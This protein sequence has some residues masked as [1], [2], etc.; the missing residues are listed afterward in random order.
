MAYIINKYS[1]EPLVNLEDGTLDTSTSL[2][3]I[4]RNYVG[5]GETQNEN[6]VYLLENF[7]NPAAPPTPLVGQLWYNTETK[8][9]NAYNGQTWSPVGNAE[10]SS[11]APYP[12][13]EGQL[14]YKVTTNQLYIYESGD[15]NLIGPTALEGFAE[16][17]WKASILIDSDGNEKPVLLSIV[18]GNVEAIMADEHFS[19]ALSN[20]IDGFFDIR[21]GLNIKST[22]RVIG[23]LTGNADTATALKDPRTIN[24]VS[25]D[26]TSNITV[27]ASTTNLLKKGT[28]ISGSNFN[29]SS[30][31]TWSIDASSENIIGKIVARDT[32]GNFSAGTVTA[33]LVG[34]V[35]GNIN[36]VGSSTFNNVTATT[37]F[38]PLS[39]NASSA[40]KLNVSRN[41]NGVPFNG[42]A[43]IVVPAESSTL[44]GDTLST[45][46]VNSSLTSVGVLTE[47]SIADQ[48]I[49]LGSGNH[50]KIFVDG[51]DP[52][53]RV[54]NNQK[55][56]VSIV[57][58]GESSGVADFSFISSTVALSLSGD[59]AP[60][61]IPTTAGTANL[62]Q[63]FAKWNKIYANSFDGY[64]SAD[65]IK[66]GIR[67]SIPYQTNTNTTGLLSIGTAGQILAVSPAG[68]PQWISGSSTNTANTI[69]S[70]DASGNFSA[71]TIT[72]S[73][74][75]TA[76]NAS[77][78]VTATRLATPRKI[79]GVNFDGTA[80][81]TVSSSYTFTYGNTSYAVG[82]TNQVGSWNNGSNFVDVFPPAGKSMGN[83]I[84]F[85]PSISVIHYAGGVNGDDS[86][87]CTWSNLGDRIRIYVQN[88]EQRS[89]PAA[90]WLAIW[91]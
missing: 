55:L 52:T 30:E 65:A 80:D 10:V 63:P 6:F 28:Y 27:T 67:G 73:L 3:L 19:I 1:G 18:N 44:T 32:L 22:R 39:G 59:D 53:I 71:G 69:V 54:A 81:I 24:G 45:S 84:A 60:A 78:S 86:M 49:N 74:I 13:T 35:I 29:G 61:L 89:T 31:V 58:S 79:N 43:D 68:I 83:L 87:R 9:V 66:G 40:S 82:Y 4:G 64:I 56:K 16:T 42:Q 26:G 76:T 46:V 8:I 23:N 70:R 25:F 21:P 36:S 41:I 90:N 85:I 20:S 11:I 17:Q 5:Y 88:T 15:W 34:N 47:L 38:G 57:D 14:W 75:G 62:G 77:A 50:V 37:F 72:A 33:N 91:S 2:G 7:A 48:G 51:L 12:G